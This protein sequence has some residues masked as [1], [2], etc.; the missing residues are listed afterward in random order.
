LCAQHKT[1]QM[2]NVADPILF[3]REMYEQIIN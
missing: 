3:A 1:V 2:T